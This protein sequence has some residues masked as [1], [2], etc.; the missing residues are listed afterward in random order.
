[1]ALE[2]LEHLTREIQDSVMAIR[3]QPV[4][5][6]FQRMPRLVREVA[7]QTGKQVRLLTEGEGTEVDKTVIERISD[8]LTHMIRNAI[9]HGLE[10]PEGRIAAGKPRE[11][12]GQA[13]RRAS[14]RPHRP[15]SVRRW[16]RHQPSA[17][18]AEGDR[19]RPDRAG[20]AAH[21]TTRST[22]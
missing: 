12:T 5:S 22:I 13:D 18:E 11:G 19:E 1:M 15:G 14:L 8:P 16:R 20:R 3:A 2:E 10:S 9:D 7:A 6:V 21:A 4:R 17:R